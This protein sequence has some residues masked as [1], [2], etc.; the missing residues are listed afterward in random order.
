MAI[1]MGLR[2]ELAGQGYAI[3]ELKRLE[4]QP[5]ATYYKA[6]GT[7]LPN[8][9]ADRRSVRRYL[10]RGFTLTPPAVSNTGPPEGSF[11]C[12]CGFEAKSAFGLMA[13]RRKHKEE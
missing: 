8:L 6:D 12:E 3:A 1:D 13:H 5:K 4:V 11:K 10:A 7:A 9:P 2:R